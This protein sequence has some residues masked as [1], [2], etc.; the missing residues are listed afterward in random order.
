MHD[1]H[2]INNFY[3]KQHSCKLRLHIID[4]TSCFSYYYYFIFIFSL[5]K[6]MFQNVLKIINLNA[7]SFFI[8]YENV[9]WQYLSSFLFGNHK[10]W[11]LPEVTKYEIIQTFTSNFDLP[12]SNEVERKHSI[13]F[14]RIAFKVWFYFV[15]NMNLWRYFLWDAWNSYKII[16]L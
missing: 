4:N 16:K 11:M 7:I 10:F 8:Q 14:F 13:K 1:T 6:K 5:D 9:K 15:G 12:K 2:N 3:R